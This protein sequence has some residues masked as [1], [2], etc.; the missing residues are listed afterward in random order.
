MD[1][2]QE[3]SKAKPMIRVCLRCLKPY[4]NDQRGCENCGCELA[5]KCP[6]CDEPFDKSFGGVNPRRRVK[7][8][9][10]CLEDIERFQ[11]DSFIDSIK[12]VP[13]EEPIEGE[14]T[15]KDG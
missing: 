3:E 5:A 14:E 1:A 12:I 9:P 4:K 11:I 6:S 10:N 8:C 7:H 2:Q 15:K 13:R